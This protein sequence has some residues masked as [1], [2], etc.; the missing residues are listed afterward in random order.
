M[1]IPPSHPRRMV[2]CEGVLPQWTALSAASSRFAAFSKNRLTN[3]FSETAG[4]ILRIF[5]L[6][7]CSTGSMDSKSGRAVLAASLIIVALLVWLW[8]RERGL[9][10]DSPAVLV[11]V[12]QLNQL[13][14]VKYTV[15]KVVGL[16]DQK[17]PV[18]S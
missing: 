11:R 14:T 9:Q 5:P 8:R 3:L 18:G 12:Q 4:W 16:K 13:T 2:Q 10:L 17:V 6:E 7:T 1:R 15:Q